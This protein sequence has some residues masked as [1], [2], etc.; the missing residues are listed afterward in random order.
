MGEEPYELVTLTGF[1]AADAFDLDAERHYATLMC[2]T[3]SGKHGGTGT[4][5][6][7]YT[8]AFEHMALKVM[9]L[10]DKLLFSEGEYRQELSM[11]FAAFREEY[12]TLLKLRVLRAFPTVFG[13]GMLDGATAIV[14]EWVEGISLADLKGRIS[15]AEAARL[16]RA[17][18]LRLEQVEGM[19]A[20][21]VHRDIAPTNI[22][23]RTDAKPLEG[24]LETG[25]FDLCLVDLGSTTVA[26][27]AGTSFTTRVGA[28]RGAT[29]SYA[30][31]ELLSL[32]SAPELRNSRKV[33]VYAIA[34]VMWEL[35]TGK[36]PYAEASLN[37]LILAK[38]QG[39]PD[40]PS[41]LDADAAKLA[42]ILARGMDPDQ[43]TRPT[44][45]DMRVWLDDSIAGKPGF[46]DGVDIA[47]PRI[48]RRGLFVGV[49][50]AAAVAGIA[51]MRPRLTAS[52][53]EEA[54]LSEGADIGSKD[55]AEIEENLLGLDS[56][57]P[58]ISLDA[59]K[60]ALLPC[61]SDEGDWGYITTNAKWA[62]PP[63]YQEVNYFSGGL[64]AVRD[65]GTGLFGFIDTMG[66]MAIE[67]RFQDVLPFGQ[68]SLAAAQDQSGLW[69]FIDR[70]G[71]WAIEPAYAAAGEFTEMAPVQ[72]PKSGL[73]GYIGESGAWTIKPSFGATDP[74]L[75]AAGAFRS[76]LAPVRM[77]GGDWAYVR[78]DGSFVENQVFSQAGEFSEGYARVV[79]KDEDE[80]GYFIDTMFDMYGSYE[81]SD[82]GR[83]SQGMFAARYTN[84]TW[85]FGSVSGWRITIAPAYSGVGR[86]I[87]GVALAQDYLTR[88]W[89]YIDMLGTWVVRPV[90]S[91]VPE[92]LIAGGGLTFSGC[93]S[94]SFVE[95]GYNLINMTCH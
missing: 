13:F 92:S 8:T 10:P 50:I 23:V 39:A 78:G 27:E 35:L 12:E 64:A 52:K 46:W 33:D 49:G 77:P 21:F 87:Q 58:R 88:R 38:R 84:G 37:H 95:I 7:A 55:E 40:V 2:L 82:V 76:G 44:A 31:P 63:Q 71:A 4:V 28:I 45:H 89:G 62:I 25:D 15:S 93:F 18:Y 54:P 94:S 6:E 47:G 79:M 5:R 68:V 73:W 75:P 53:A 32:D 56:H 36:P 85:G 22:I 91:G 9:A 41:G 72:D 60:G 16:A 83:V 1:E 11:R 3:K 29:P 43:Q 65:A 66:N 48:T 57:A 86:F 80:P 59:Y 42:R 81:Y 51:F 20:A 69:G 70:S 67:P 61:L 24:Q 90:M 14:M 19:L 26:R 34:S 30:A 74:K 17:L